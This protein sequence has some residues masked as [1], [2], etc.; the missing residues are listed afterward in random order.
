VA[1]AWMGAALLSGVLAVACRTQKT[2]T[3]ETAGDEL[4][5]VTAPDRGEISKDRSIGTDSTVVRLPD[6]PR[7]VRVL[8]GPPPARRLGE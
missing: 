2:A 3:S 1:L 8:Y 5:E 6:D 7:R 4:P